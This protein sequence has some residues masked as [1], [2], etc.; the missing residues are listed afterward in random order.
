MRYF[1]SN[2]LLKSSSEISF[3]FNFTDFFKACVSFESMAR[4]TKA[5]TFSCF[6][7]KSLT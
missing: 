3:S 2:N 5:S 6:F 1:S 4:S 7:N